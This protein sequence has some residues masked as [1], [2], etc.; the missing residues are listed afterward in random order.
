[1]K[2][3]GLLFRRDD[4]TNILHPNTDP[5]AHQKA[6]SNAQSAIAFENHKQSGKADSQKN[7]II[8]FLFLNDGSTLDEISDGVNISQKGTVTARFKEIRIAGYDLIN[9]HGYW[10]IK[11]RITGNNVSAWGIVK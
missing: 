11:K 9:N 7:R 4:A 3:Q 2:Q 10:S 8:D 1:M 5:F 6:A